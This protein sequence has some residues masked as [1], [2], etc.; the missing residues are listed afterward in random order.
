M[1]IELF[2]YELPDDRIARYP[3]ER[4]DGARLLV[5]DPIANSLD[6]R[7]IVDLPSLIPKGALVVVNDTRV[8]KARLFGEKADTGGRVEVFL[9]EKLGVIGRGERWRALGRASK[10]LRP[11]Q[12][13]RLEGGA[14]VA[15][16]EARGEDGSLE[17][18]LEAAGEETVADAIEAHGRVPLPPYMQRA[19][20][21]EDVERYQ[22]VYAK[23]P[24]AVAAPTAGL[25]LSHELLEAL[26]SRDV[27]IATLT[28]HVGLGTFQPVTVDDLDAHPMHEESFEVTP[29]LAEAI[30]E[31]RRRAKPVI[32]IGTTVVRALESAAKEEGS[33]L[34][35]PLRA[36]TRL[37]I[38]PGYSFRIV[39]ALLTNFH[40]PRSTLLALVSA[41]AGRERVLHA[42]AEA[43]SRG[44]RFY[45]YGDAMFIPSRGPEV[46]R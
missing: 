2:D 24:G 21:E 42:Y 33:G 13:L 16:I 27:E 36:A 19:P 45:S 3:A 6:D 38:Q 23:S 10:S 40:L 32:A 39:D 34:V 20:G 43:I 41:F 26:R 17:I 30:A 14:L 29:A 25:H 7:N 8:V 4:R 11:G 5:L 44:Y 35:R 31:A 46:S 12:L 18:V 9:V 28:L 22:T 37:L 15:R 1:R